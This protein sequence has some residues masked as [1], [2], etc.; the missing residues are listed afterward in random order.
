MTRVKGTPEQERARGLRNTRMQQRQ[1]TA[2]LRAALAREDPAEALTA[3][4]DLTPAGGNANARDL[5]D[6]A[7]DRMVDATGPEL[8][9]LRVALAAMEAAPEGTDLIGLLIEQVA[10]T[11]DEREL[12]G[13]EAALESVLHFDATPAYEVVEQV[14][15]RR[16]ERSR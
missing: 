1:A 13:F 9:G 4:L 14:R 7:D 15:A 11:D 12:P 6:A 16:E 3:G 8:P 5:I 10:D 2:R